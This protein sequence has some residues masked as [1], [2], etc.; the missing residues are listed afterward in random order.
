M[1]IIDSLLKNKR[2]RLLRILIGKLL[3]ITYKGLYTCR[4]ITVMLSGNIDISTSA[5]KLRM[6]F[7]NMYIAIAATAMI[8]QEPTD[9]VDWLGS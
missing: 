8:M 4:P 3:S 7:F 1:R 2:A 9:Y 6:I 5:V